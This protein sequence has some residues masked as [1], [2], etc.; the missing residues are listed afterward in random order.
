MQPES[1]STLGVRDSEYSSSSTATLSSALWV[2]SLRF[3]R[4]LRICDYS[5][6]LVKILNVSQDVVRDTEWSKS[7]QY[8]AA[9]AL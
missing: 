9:S 4:I 3:L 5:L 6:Y 1:K 2:S 7:L 8:C